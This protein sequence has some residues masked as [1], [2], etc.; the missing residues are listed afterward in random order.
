MLELKILIEDSDYIS[1][2]R[3]I[4]P[5]IYKGGLKAKAAIFATTKM[6]KDKSQDEQ[7]E[8]II[9]FISS[10]TEKLISTLNKKL[11]EY[12]A[13]ASVTH[14]EIIKQGM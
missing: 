5:I 11:F 3:A 6:L 4:A 13:S 7:E 8:I 14:I 12:G 2:V 9:E 1:T 10:R